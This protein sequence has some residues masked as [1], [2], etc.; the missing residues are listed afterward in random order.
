MTRRAVFLDRDGTLIDEFGYLGD[1]DGVRLLPG[2]IHAVRRLNEAGW[3]AVVVTNQSGVARGLFDDAA[4]R[5]V[6]GRLEALLAAGGAHLDLVLYCPHH[7]GHG[8]GALRTRC[9]CRKPE[10]GLLRTAAERLGLDLPACWTIGDSE[11][12]LEAGRRAGLAGG[13]LV[14]TGKGAAVLAALA[15]ERRA[16]LRVARDVDRAVELVL[17]T[18]AAGQGR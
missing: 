14:E 16:A 4:V 2:A 9:A 1:P 11:R 12:D 6:H 7:P 18:A 15:P 13:V 8:T 3:K 5:A 10:P 17:A